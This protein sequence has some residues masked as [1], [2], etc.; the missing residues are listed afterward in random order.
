MMA[1]IP[2]MCRA[3]RS[4]EPAAAARRTNISQR[5]L[6]STNSRFF[7]VSEEVQQA[8][9]E[10]RPVVALESTIYTHGFPYPDNLSLASR[11]ESL[12]RVNGGVPATIG[13]LDGIARVGMGADELIRLVSSAGKPGLLKV[14]RRDLGFVC[15]LT[16][17][18]GKSLNG[19]TTVSA[20]MILAHK[21]GIRVFATGGLGGVHRG[22]EQT[23]D[24]SADLT[25]L[26]RTPVAVFSSG[27]KSFLDIPKTLEYLETQG[28]AVATFADGREGKVDFPAFYSRDS[29]VKSPMVVRDEEGAARVIYAHTSLGLQSGLHF[30]NPIPEQH[31]IPYNQ[32]ETAISQALKEA[33]AA[34]ATGAASTPYILARIK[35]I[36]GSKSVTANRA[37][38]EANVIRG[39]KVAV[40]LLK[41]M[42]DDTH[43]SE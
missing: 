17:A 11:L 43:H 40:A 12:V 1:Q 32:M 39:T 21:A 16:G 9:A 6:L 4:V 2:W 23:M 13:V 37:L 3:C 22:V 29:G 18:D 7:Q 24:V 19:G 38:V 14:S 10:H 35:D 27:C 30:A 36:T 42:T 15:G 31:S 5:R 28:V 41:L 33:H 20:T 8:I 25:E 26:G 34:G